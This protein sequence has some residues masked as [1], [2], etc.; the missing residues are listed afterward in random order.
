MTVEE[1]SL[2]LIGVIRV[3][4][5]FRFLFC[6][7][8]LQVT[9]EERGRYKKRA[10]NVIVFYVIAESIWQIKDMVYYYYQ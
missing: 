3:G 1:L 5:I 10:K 8:Q 7:I 4:A 9:E 6:M 2:A